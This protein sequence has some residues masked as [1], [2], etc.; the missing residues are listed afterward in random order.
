MKSYLLKFLWIIIVLLALL[1]GY[2]PIAYLYYG[3]GEG[4]LAMKSEA[5]KGSQ[6]WWVFL[7]THM[8]SGGIAILIGWVQFSKW[9]QKI[10]FQFT[11]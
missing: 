3:V 9:M 11:E 2:I 8:I 7:Y 10:E 1:V 5:V 6:I 4:Y